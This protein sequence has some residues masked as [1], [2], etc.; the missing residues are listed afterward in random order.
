MAVADVERFRRAL[1]V[2]RAPANI[3]GRVVWAQEP[4]VY[5]RTWLI[6]TV[7]TY[8]IIIYQAVFTVNLGHCGP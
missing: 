3:P 5:Y 6:D 4:A 7:Y 8:Y 2:N 1:A